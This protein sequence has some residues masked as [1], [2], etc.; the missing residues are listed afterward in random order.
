MPSL[1][2]KGICKPKVP[3]TEVTHSVAYVC[4]YKDKVRGLVFYFHFAIAYWELKR[5]AAP[6]KPFTWCFQ[7]WNK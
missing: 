2:S 5:M 7:I 4:P 6:V 3:F 1:I